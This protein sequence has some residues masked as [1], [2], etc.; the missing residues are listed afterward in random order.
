MATVAVVG[1]I[2]AIFGQN[3]KELGSGHL[4]MWLF[5]VASAGAL[6]LAYFIFWL[7][8]WV[9]RRPQSTSERRDA[10]AP[11]RKTQGNGSAQS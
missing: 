5:A 1:T 11:T 9:T 2:A 8:V 7:A 10:A 6:L 4:S 3:F